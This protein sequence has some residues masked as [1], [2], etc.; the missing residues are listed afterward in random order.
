C[1]SSTRCS[2]AKASRRSAPTT[3][4]ATCATSG[5]RPSRCPGRSASPA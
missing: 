5:R 1:V 4:T 2:L 3:G